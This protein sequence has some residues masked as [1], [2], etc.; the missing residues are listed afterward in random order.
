MTADSTDAN[1]RVMRI[2]RSL[3]SLL[4][5]LALCV[6][7]RATIVDQLDQ[8][9]RELACA[10]WFN[11]KAPNIAKLKGRVVLLHFS[12]PDKL[13]S[14]AFVGNIRKI[15]EKYGEKGLTVIEVML[16]DD[17]PTAK[18]YVAAQKIDWLIGAD[19]E[20]K[21]RGNYLGTSEPRSYLVGPDGKIVFHAHVGALKDSMIQGQLDRMEFFDLKKVPAKA[22]AL[23]KA[24]AAQRYA[25]ALKEVEKIKKDPHADDDTRR[26]AKLAEADMERDHKFQLELLDDNIRTRDLGVAWDRLLL[27]MKRYKGTPQHDE[28]VKRHLELKEDERAVW[29]RA[30]QIELDKMLEKS[31]SRKKSDI[32][33]LV[34]KLKEFAE[35]VGEARPGEKARDWIKLLEKRLERMR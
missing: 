23:A 12:N 13:T 28:F 8:P 10:E 11:G 25:A 31:N 24:T 14:K 35:F 3:L 7:A 21:A 18:S 1:V 2:A 15:H 20:H 27:L 17:L 22:K 34:R 9:A 32:E 4:F 29:V 6:V 5:V 19:T 30:K 26:L 16:V 33:K